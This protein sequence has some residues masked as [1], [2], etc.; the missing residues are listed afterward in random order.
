MSDDDGEEHQVARAWNSRTRLLRLPL[1]LRWLWMA[2]LCP[3]SLMALRRASFH[4]GIVADEAWHLSLVKR[5]LARQVHTH[6]LEGYSPQLQ[7]MLYARTEELAAQVKPQAL[8]AAAL[9]AAQSARHAIPIYTI[10]LAEILTA[11][12]L[13][14]LGSAARE[15]ASDWSELWRSLLD[16]DVRRASHIALSCVPMACMLENGRVPM[17]VHA[18]AAEHLLSLAN[19]A[20]STYDRVEPEAHISISIATGAIGS[21]VRAMSLHSSHE[22]VQANGAYALGSMCL[23]VQKESSAT[24]A[25]RQRLAVD[26]GAF[27]A[28][29]A[30]MR[31]FPTSVQVQD[32]GCMALDWITKDHGH[33]HCPSKHKLVVAAA[34]AAGVLPALVGALEFVTAKEGISDTFESIFDALESILAVSNKST[35]GTYPSGLITSLVQAIIYLKATSNR[36]DW[37]ETD[38]GIRALRAIAGC[39]AQGHAAVLQAGAPPA[40]L[41]LDGAE[42]GDYGRQ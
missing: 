33:G 13:N 6:C 31:A 10:D 21:I 36:T 30:A 25:A 9:H 26:A 34:V 18:A 3:S 19:R 12:S 37:P 20:W 2:H 14:H 41:E 22:L 23:F 40:W 35:V 42:Y 11:L 29:V 7:L 39:S 38:S 24:L 1:E 15:S 32:M 5:I 4:F 16:S 8:E 17:Q 27:T 28:I